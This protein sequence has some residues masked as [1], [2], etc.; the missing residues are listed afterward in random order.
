MTILDRNPRYTVPEAMGECTCEATIHDGVS[1]QHTLPEDLSWSAPDTCVG[2]CDRSWGYVLCFSGVALSCMGGW[3]S[4]YVLKLGGYDDAPMHAAPTAIPIAHQPDEQ[5]ALL[6][7]SRE[8]AADA[9]LPI[10]VQSIGLSVGPKRD[11]A[12]TPE[13]QQALIQ[14]TSASSTGC[15]FNA[16]ENYAGVPSNTSYPSQTT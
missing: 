8:A 15:A 6:T 14:S 16:N 7:G 12:I 4:I 3:R 2:A 1:S 5:D 10:L 13:H 9:M 11:L